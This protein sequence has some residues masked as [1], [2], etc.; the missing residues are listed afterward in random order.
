ML[1]QILFIPTLPNVDNTGASQEL[2]KMVKLGAIQ[3]LMPF[4]LLYL[5]DSFVFN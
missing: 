2:V 5:L 4:I 3:L 1:L